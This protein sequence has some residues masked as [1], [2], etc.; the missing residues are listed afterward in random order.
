MKV[1]LGLL[2][3][4]LGFWGCSTTF[5]KN[6]KQVTAKTWN[7]KD[8]YAKQ[9]KNKKACYASNKNYAKSNARSIASSSNCPGYSSIIYGGQTYNTGTI[10]VTNDMNYVNVNLASNTSSNWLIKAVHIYIGQGPIPTNAQG[11][12]APGQFPYKEEFETLQSGL[13]YEFPLADLAIEC[14]TKV[15]MAVHTV[16]VRLGSSGEVLQEE[17]GWAYGPNAFDSTRWGWS[18]DYTLCCDQP[19][20][21]G[22]TLT[23]GYWKTHSKYAKL[24]NLKINWPVS[25]DTLLCGKT[26]Y[27]ILNTAPK[28][29]DAWTILAHQWIAAKL[30]KAMGA[31]SEDMVQT[32][33]VS[34]ESMLTSNCSGISSE[35]RQTALEYSLILD[36]YN[37]G[38][39][40]PG[41]CE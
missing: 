29:G 22:C 10:Q 33:L 3:M 36:N 2:A 21:E 25:E 20:N 31:S 35:Q 12:P 7:A 4:S 11:V 28:T 6:P 34:G 15:N 26:W 40:G 41:H 1:I 37:N 32:A 8:H 38:I 30:N 27:S 23:Q 24:R 39:I 13:T 14:G 19:N 18:F 16:M 17:T 5:Q 9:A